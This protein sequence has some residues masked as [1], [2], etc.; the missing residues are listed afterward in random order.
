[1]C[2]NIPHAQI[3][4]KSNS[5]LS[6]LKCTIHWNQASLSQ[7]HQGYLNN[8]KS[9]TAVHLVDGLIKTQHLPKYLS[10]CAKSTWQN[11]MSI[12]VG[13]RHLGCCPSPGHSPFPV[14]CTHS[15]MGSD[16]GCPRASP[17]SS[18][19]SLPSIC[20]SASRGFSVACWPPLKAATSHLMQHSSRV[21]LQARSSSTDPS[22]AAEM[23]SA[24]TQLQWETGQHGWVRHS[25]TS[26]RDTLSPTPHRPP[27]KG[28]PGP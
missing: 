4:A 18:S 21:F 1:M 6:I 26:S 12:P 20:C 24:T 2:P 19:L 14:P 15:L 13:R 16:S 5:A 23:A 27:N 10:G 3:P 25:S 9:M 22:N 7:E 17:T 8:Q 11:L 28:S